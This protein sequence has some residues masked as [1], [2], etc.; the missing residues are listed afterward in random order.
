MASSLLPTNCTFMRTSPIAAGQRVHCRAGSGVALPFVMH[1]SAPE[2]VQHSVVARHGA[3][4][5]LADAMGEKVVAEGFPRFRAVAFAPF[6][7]FA[8]EV[9]DVVYLVSAI[10]IC[11]NGADEPL[12]GMDL[13]ED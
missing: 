8:D 10:N 6:L 1:S 2:D 9:A 12:L 3:C 4:L 7:L 5:D 13:A 11:S